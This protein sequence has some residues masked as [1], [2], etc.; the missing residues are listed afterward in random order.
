MNLMILNCLNYVHGLTGKALI[1]LKSYLTESY[2]MVI[3]KE[4]Q[5]SHMVL[6]VGLPQGS[7]L[8]SKKYNTHKNPWVILFG[9]IKL[10][11]KLCR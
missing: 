1:C 8:D 7:V 9:N 6:D 5:Y 4:K 11:I 3:V 10:I 2:Q